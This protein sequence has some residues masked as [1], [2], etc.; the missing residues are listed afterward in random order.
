MNSWV[1]WYANALKIGLAI[2]VVMGLYDW[3]QNTAAERDELCSV[4]QSHM[5]VSEGDGYRAADSAYWNYCAEPD[6]PANDW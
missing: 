3:A 1:D 6:Q 4:I 2:L 5:E